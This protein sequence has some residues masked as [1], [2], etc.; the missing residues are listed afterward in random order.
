MTSRLQNEDSDASCEEIETLSGVAA[1]P[2]VLAGGR[3]S[4]TVPRLLEFT[5]HVPEYRMNADDLCNVIVVVTESSA[6]TGIFTAKVVEVCA[7]VSSIC[8]KQTTVVPYCAWGSSECSTN[9]LLN[10]PP[11]SRPLHLFGDVLTRVPEERLKLL[12]EVGQFTSCGV[13]EI[14]HQVVVGWRGGGCLDE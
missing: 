8:G 1:L 4:Y 9:A 5:Q 14:A 6:G 3:A 12:Y 13:V 2:D 7:E 10:H 11:E